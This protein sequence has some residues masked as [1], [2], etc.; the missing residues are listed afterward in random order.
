MR[1]FRRLESVQ[2]GMANDILQKRHY[3]VLTLRAS[4]FT[5]TQRHVL[6]K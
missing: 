6:S 2:L 1:E 5:V 3:D 4:G